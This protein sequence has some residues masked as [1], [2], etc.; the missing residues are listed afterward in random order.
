[1]SPLPRTSFAP[2]FSLF[3]LWLAHLSNLCLSFRSWLRCPLSPSQT[4]PI[5]HSSLVSPK[6]H[7]GSLFIAARLPISLWGQTQT[8]SVGEGAESSKPLVHWE[9]LELIPRG[10][11]NHGELRNGRSAKAQ[12]PSALHLSS[13]LATSQ[14]ITASGTNTFYEPISSHDTV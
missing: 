10:P 12:S 1:M 13:L 4:R 6:T 9:D 2:C 7:T 11:E 5:C 8:S 3:I 14:S